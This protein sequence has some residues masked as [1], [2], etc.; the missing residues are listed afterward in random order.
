[1]TEHLLAIHIGPVQ[2]FIAAARRTADL[3]A[4][5]QL[6]LETVGA[7]AAT[8]DDTDRIFPQNP[9]GGG[10]NRILTFVDDDPAAALRKAEQ[11]ARDH[12]VRSWDIHTGRLSD[13]QRQALDLDR[14]GRQIRDFLT[15]MGAW[16]PVAS[17]AEYGKAR[18][19][20][21][22][23]LRGR[24]ATRDFSPASEDDRGLPKS[25]LDPSLPTIRRPGKEHDHALGQGP[26]FLKRTESLDAVS[27]LKR[28]KGVTEGQK[29][30]STRA[31]AQRAKDPEATDSP[32]RDDDRDG[33]DT[34]PDH[35]YFAIVV[36]DGDRMG[37]LLGRLA[38]APDGV[39]QHLDIGR[40]LDRFAAT[41]RQR[42]RGSGQ[43]VYCGGDDVMAFLPV[44]TALT[45]T[46]DLAVEFRNTL[47]DASSLSAGIAVVHYK[48]PLSTGL[49]RARRAE[50]EAK[51]LRDAVCVAIHTRGG[52]PRVITCRWEHLR[53]DDW[54]R[55]FAEDHLPAGLPYELHQLAVGWPTGLP[56]AALAA[57]AERVIDRKIERT[58]DSDAVKASLVRFI[59]EA[60]AVEDPA[61]ALTR[62][63]EEL[64]MARFLAGTI[65]EKE[66][67]R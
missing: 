2:E 9:G 37:Q 11:A 62:I 53:L 45:I 42:L 32:T 3:W 14:G 39:Q 55:H 13:A 59:A 18:E 52:F 12:L 6:L 64:T 66:G 43:P 26:L 5:S 8:F 21:E 57:E 38:S 58:Q 30:L 33:D 46:R 7:A 61:E 36:A 56:A 41:A 48:E 19:R 54:Q 16:V 51:R 50:Q 22:L 67:D 25:P 17:R 24:K 49:A 31:L 47:G 60:L 34:P 27:L 28:I 4:G 29:V 65:Q 44:T 23:L 35:A 1:M 10:A 40:R 15:V 20:V 63:A